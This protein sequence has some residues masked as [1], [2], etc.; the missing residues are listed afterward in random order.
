MTYLVVC[1]QAVHRGAAQGVGNHGQV[2]GFFVVQLLALPV[3]IVC[4]RFGLAARF[5]LRQHPVRV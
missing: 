2:V 5:L 3:F 1:R 4:I